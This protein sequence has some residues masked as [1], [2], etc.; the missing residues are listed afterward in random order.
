M[1]R[2]ASPA[3]Q[4]P[5]G[6]NAHRHRQ[7]QR[8][9][10]MHLPCSCPFQLVGTNGDRPGGPGELQG[11]YGGSCQGSCVPRALGWEQYQCSHAQFHGVR[12]TQCFTTNSV[13]TLADAHPGSVYDA[14]V[15]NNDV[16]SVPIFLT[17]LLLLFHLPFPGGVLRIINPNWLQLVS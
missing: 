8:R 15:R 12:G 2:G 11:V 3:L 13:A 16:F 4:T 6:V 17:L 14:L 1:G 5:L 9:D 7:A 10:F